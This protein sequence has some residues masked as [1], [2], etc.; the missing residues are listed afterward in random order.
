MAL[1]LTSLVLKLFL[2]P[3]ISNHLYPSFKFKMDDMTMS[4]VSGTG[5]FIKIKSNHLNLFGF[6]CW[7]NSDIK[8]GR[9]SR[10]SL[11][12]DILVNQHLF[13]AI[14]GVFLKSFYFFKLLDHS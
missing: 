3:S 1:C 4:E 10:L 5:Q 12:R 11:Q 2:C 6:W 13:K 8:T 14:A 9:I 7:Q